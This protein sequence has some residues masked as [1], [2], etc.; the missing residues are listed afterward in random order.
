[1][2][3]FVP[4]EWSSLTS[5]SAMNVPFTPLVKVERVQTMLPAPVQ[6]AWPWLV[7][8]RSVKYL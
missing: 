8:S 2:K 4:S 3:V 7:R 6:V 5:L 1:M